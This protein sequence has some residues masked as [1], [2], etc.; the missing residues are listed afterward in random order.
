MQEE[1]S[2]TT[3]ENGHYKFEGFVPGYYVI[4]Y[5]YDDQTHYLD[6]DG[7]PININALD[8]K[9]A[10]IT[11]N[12]KNY[13]GGDY[14]ANGELKWYLKDNPSETDKNT[15]SSSFDKY[16]E[17]VDNWVKRQKLDYK[18]INYNS[19]NTDSEGNVTSSGTMDAYTP[20]FRINVELNTLSQ[21]NRYVP[22]GYNISNMDFGITERAVQD[23]EI[24]KEV[25]NTKIMLANGQVLLDGDPKTDKMSGLK[26]LEPMGPNT[27]NPNGTVNIELDSEL[28][29]GSTLELTYAIKVN[30]IGEK[31][32]YNEEYYKYG[33]NHEKEV[34]ISPQIY[35]YVDTALT[36]D[37]AVN[38][39]WDKVDINKFTSDTTA[40]DKLIVEQNALTE[41]KTHNDIIH[42]N[43]DI[44]LP[45]GTE[46][47]LTLILSRVLSN[48]DDPLTYDNDVEM[49]EGSKTKG[50]RIEKTKRT[51]TQLTP[52]GTLKTT[53]IGDSSETTTITP[54]TG[55]NRD[56]L[57]YIITGIG[58]L[59]ILAAGI[60]I[61]KKKVIK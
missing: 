58:A 19:V 47:N 46:N 26:Y 20:A 4:V 55:E 28:I 21:E 31:D 48:S 51:G 6:A 43:Q 33:T 5:T 7:N 39:N 27:P 57:I 18:E 2:A 38:P 16:T 54:P 53:S 41:I 22:E 10:V 44:S 56:Y 13:H 35:D 49:V 14:F 12:N 61:I 40:E 1:L 17:A 37:K 15:D 29:H 23:I 30:N 45:A 42:Y 52:E 34:V 32:Y 24:T 11:D 36:F 60:I 9:S 3:D 8:Y 59:L 50:R 25:S